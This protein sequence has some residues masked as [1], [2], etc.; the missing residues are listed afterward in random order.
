MGQRR[1]LYVGSSGGCRRY[2]ARDLDLGFLIARLFT[3]P[4]DVLKLRVDTGILR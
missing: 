3:Q 2:E 4:R 1:C